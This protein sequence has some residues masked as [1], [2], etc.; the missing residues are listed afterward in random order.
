MEYIPI[1]IGTGLKKTCR[2]QMDRLTGPAQDVVLGEAA[3][4]EGEG[5]TVIKTSHL[6]VHG[7]AVVTTPTPPT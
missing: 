2:T 5:R 1:R 3:M 7:G 4:L 6:W